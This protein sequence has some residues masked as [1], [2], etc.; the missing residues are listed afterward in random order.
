M[1]E[2]ITQSMMSSTLIANIQSMTTQLTQTE[3]ELS[4]GKRITKPSD[5][6][7]GTGQAL[8]YDADLA[9]NAQQQTNVNDGT[10]WLNTADTA[11]SDI[12]SSVLRVRDLVVQGASSSTGPS[13]NLDI[14][15]EVDQIIDS[16]KSD[17]NTQYAGKY[18]FAGTNTGTAP[19]TVGGADT[20]AGDAGAVNREIGP[21]VQVQVNIPGSSILGDGSTPGSMIATLRQISADLKSNNT[22]A[23]GSTDLAALD[24]VMTNVSTVQATVGA[25]EDR[26][27]SALSRLQQVQQSTTALLSTDQDADIAQVTIDYSQQEAVFQSALKAGAQIIQPSLLDYLTTA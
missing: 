20:Y 2:R 18:I 10:A 6:P 3:A 12:N 8:L 25:R 16:I 4:S 9:S 21:G 26:L 22:T 19:Y 11:L 1:S 14:A 24:S 13:G 27:T 15:A 23:L 17:G 7:F 5:D